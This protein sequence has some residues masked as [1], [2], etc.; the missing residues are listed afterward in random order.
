MGKKKNSHALFDLI[1]P[2]PSE[3]R[4]RIG[5]ITASQS[6]LTQ[7]NGSNSN[8]YV[9]IRSVFNTVFRDITNLIQQL[10]YS[11]HMVLSLLYNIQLSDSI[12][13]TRLAN[14]CHSYLECV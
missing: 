10:L 12:C 3:K 1:S 8:G 7:R 11:I 4:P 6:Q 13:F 2:P 14:G 5:Q 9:S